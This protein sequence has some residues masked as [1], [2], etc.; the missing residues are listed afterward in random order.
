MLQDTLNAR[1]A[2]HYDIITIQYK[3]NAIV[4]YAGF[5]IAKKYVANRLFFMQWIIN[6]LSY[7]PSLSGTK[8]S[9]F[10]NKDSN[11]FIQQFILTDLCVFIWR[12]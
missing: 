7:F 6:T 12:I 4:Y 3:R 5:E 9:A 8:F 2:S 11:I 10:S 1:S